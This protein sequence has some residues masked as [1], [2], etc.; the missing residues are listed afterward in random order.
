MEDQMANPKYESLSLTAT[1]NAIRRADTV[2]LTV[3]ITDKEFEALKQAKGRIDFAII[4]PDSGGEPVKVEPD[5]SR[6]ATWKPGAKDTYGVHTFRAEVWDGKRVR[7]G[8]VRVYLLDPA[9][10]AS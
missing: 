5:P 9:E 4:A 2:T 3:G 7:C 1:P 6:T 10:G 8:T